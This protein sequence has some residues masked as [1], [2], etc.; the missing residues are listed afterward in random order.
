MKKLLFIISLLF[1]VVAQ[2][3]VRF[4]MLKSEGSGGSTPTVEKTVRLNFLNQYAGSETNVPGWQGLLNTGGTAVTSGTYT[5]TALRDVNN[6]NSGWAFTL[7]S[8]GIGENSGD[9]LGSTAFGCDESI[10]RQSWTFGNGNAFRLY[11]LE[12]NRTYRI[13]YLSYSWWYDNF[14]GYLTANGQTG[15]NQ[16]N[17]IGSGNPWATGDKYGTCTESGTYDVNDTH[18]VFIETTSNSSGEINFTVNLV[19]GSYFPVN[20]IIIQR[21]SN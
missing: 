9:A 2:A 8:A 6:V 3:Q 18:L 5:N 12:P 21:M 19:A 17:P 15:T 7:T 14:S 13:Y 1:S 16:G 10:A 11:N 20:A 4:L